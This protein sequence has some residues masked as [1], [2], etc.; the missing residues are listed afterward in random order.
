MKN[1]FLS[2]LNLFHIHIALLLLR[3]GTGALMLTHGWPKLDR[4]ITQNEIVFPDP[5]GIG[6]TA[7]LALAIFAEFF[8]SIMLI[9]G[10]AT[11]VA[12]FLIAVTMMVAVFIVH[13]NDPF[14]RMEL[15]LLYLVNAIFLMISGGGKISLDRYIYNN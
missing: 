11:R 9:F 13:A 12:A 10:L 6:P 15:G 5:L 7:S 8:G 4:L 3:M 1:I 2:S 14:S